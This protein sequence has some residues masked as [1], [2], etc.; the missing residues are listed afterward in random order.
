MNFRA[1]SFST[2][3]R[4][5]PRVDLTPLIDIVFL[6]LIFFLITTTFVKERKPNIPINVP[7]ASSAEVTPKEDGLTI[8][9]T[10]DGKLF[11][12]D[13]PKTEEELGGLLDEIK[14]RNP[15]T[16][17]LIRADERTQHGVIV[18]IMDMAKQK[19]LHRFGIISRRP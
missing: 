11:V 4:E 9:V 14:V 1:G 5:D 18:R 17:V 15:K 6:L 7:A 12:K 16:P 10:Q 3:R 13:E 8:H 19:G 2:R